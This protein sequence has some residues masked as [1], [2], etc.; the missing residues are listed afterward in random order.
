MLGK[1]MKYEW[2]NIWKAGTLML[3]GMLVVTVIGCVVLRMPGGLV[4]EIADG[5][6]MNATQSWFVLSSFVA[7]LILYVIMLLASTWGMLIFLGIRF[8]RSMYTD[9]GYLSHT[10][11]VTANQLFL[12]KVLVSGVWYLFITIGIGISVVALIVS[13]MTGLLN[14]GEL[15]S[16]LTQ[17]NGNIWEFLADAFYELG[18]TYEE[19]MGINLL[20]YGITLLLTYVAGPFI[21]MVTLF[22]ALT[23]G[24]LS[25]KHK[26][27]MGILAY[28]GLTILSSI[29]GSTVQSAFMFGANVANSASDEINMTISIPTDDD[30]YVLLQCEHCGTYFK[31]TPSDLKDDGVLHIF[32]PGCGLISVNYITEDVLELAVKMVTNAVNDMIYNEFKKM[33]RHSKKGIITFKAGKRPKHENEDPIHSGIE[34]MEICNF[35]CCKRTAKIKP[36]L[37]MTGAY[38][39]F[40]GVKN[41]EIE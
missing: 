36:L 8:Y 28:A 2:K 40:C 35:P 6:N 15:S 12:S 22:G 17:Y 24:Q 33:E 13:L 25:S 34:A 19:E 30:G 18:R 10:L 27:L 38:C 3:L 9:E 32:C 31:A 41:Y 1:L 20:H 5:N 4:T 37:K 11:P 14:I 16:V 39:P 29:I 21:T 26:G 23:I 7:T